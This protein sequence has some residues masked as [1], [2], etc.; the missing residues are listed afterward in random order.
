GID[1]N[2]YFGDPVANKI[3]QYN[4]TTGAIKEFAIPTP[5]ANPFGFTLGVDGKVYFTEQAAGKVG[6]LTYF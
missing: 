6:Q 3:A 4:V 2:F 5:G 1:N